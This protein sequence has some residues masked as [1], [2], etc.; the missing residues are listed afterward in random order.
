MRKIWNEGWKFNLN[1]SPEEL[2]NEDWESIQL[3]HDWLIYDTT[4]LYRDGYGRYRKAFDTDAERIKA[5]GTHVFVVFDGVYMD[6][7]YYLNGERIG[8]WKYGYSQ[9]VLELPAALLKK[10]GN[11]LLVTVNYRSPNSRWYSGAGIY[12]DVTY[13]ETP[14]V[15]IPEN[16]VY[17][18]MQKAD[19]GYDVYVD[20]EICGMSGAGCEITNS[21]TD[22]TGNM[23]DITHIL[24]KLLSPDEYEEHI[25]EGSPMGHRQLTS[26][27]PLGLKVQAY[28]IDVYHVVSPREW[29][30]ED[31]YL[32]CLETVLDGQTV[33]NRIGFKTAFCDVDKGFFLNGSHMKLNGVCEHHDLGVLGAEFNKAAMRR[34]LEILRGMGVNAIRGTHNMMA[35]G[36]LELCDEMGILYISEAFDMWNHPKTDYDY[37]R[38]FDDWHERDVASW[39]RRDRNH[40]CVIMWSIGNEIAD[41]HNY[42]KEG[43][44]MTK[45]LM[46]LVACHDYMAN[47]YITQGSNYMPWENAQKCADILKVAGYN[48]GESCYAQHHEEHPDWVIYGSETSSITQSRGV[49]HLPLSANSLGEEDEQCSALGNSTTSWSAKSYELCAAIDRDTPFS[50]GQFLWS[51]FDYIGEPTPYKTRSCYFGQIDTAG[52]PKDSY[53]FWKSCWVSADKDPFVH[54]FPYWDFNEG[55]TVDVRVVSNLPEVELFINGRS[56]GRQSLDHEPGSGYHLIAD[57]RIAY[58]TG[59]LTATAYASA[60]SADVAVRAS[61]HSFGDT[62]HL[63]A[64][65]Y[66]FSSTD[67]PQDI[68]FYEISAVDSEGYAV[69]NACDRVHVRV[70]SGGRL[71]G[72]DNGDS[73]DPDGYRTDSRRLFN[74]KLMV[75]VALDKAN[76]E[77]ERVIDEGCG[78]YVGDPDIRIELEDG[79]KD[80]RRIS[81]MCEDDRVLTPDHRTVKVRSRIEPPAAAGHKMTYRIVDDMGISSHLA[82]LDVS[83]ATAESGANTGE[84]PAVTG[85]ELT[86]TALGDGHFR[87]RATAGGEGQAVRVIS[88]LEFDVEGCGDAFRNP[89]EFI[90]GSTYSSSIGEVGSGNEK[91][92]ATARGGRTV[93]TFDGLDFG[94]YGA[95]RITIPIFALDSDD[96]PL[97]VWKGVPGSGDEI[98]LLD[99]VYSKP[100]QWAVFIEDSWPLMHRVSGV[101]SISFEFERKV[102]VKGFVFDKSD[103]AHS[104]L[105]ATEADAI[106]GDEFTKT[107]TAVEM[108]G[109][110]V[111]LEYKDMDFGTEG[112]DSITIWGRTP[113]ETNPIHVRLFRGDEALKEVCEFTRSEEYVSQTFK[114]PHI[115]GM[116]DVSFVF[117]PG[118]AFDFEAFRFE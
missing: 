61:V 101:A 46:E 18:H 8:E 92:F 4:D 26:G 115:E 47:A 77:S 7:A 73:S 65:R 117:L 106:Y 54:I 93:V 1:D 15:Y 56:L 14:A 45:H 52:F 59:E 108:I 3:P 64:R 82:T 34:K 55:Q 63:V 9:Y 20:T 27:D 89:Y 105:S 102:H 28:S 81:L 6:S 25:C 84:I 99:T 103:K 97:K 98:L 87:L 35:A 68:A 110:N 36:L 104:R 67:E 70:V 57:Y 50:Q 23:V 96:V 111:S 109:N 43:Q 69:E 78:S 44:A 22:E 41:I 24:H 37:A 32:Y 5:E 53:Y 86:I 33:M 79:E 21:L 75:A 74:G 48:Y 118:S 88:D 100:R 95:D 76:D 114:L 90:A 11:E 42:E 17:I 39:V 66:V 38:F 85:D 10:S 12:R 49:Y 80:V 2:N 60:G 107:G 58:E 116:W 19:D 30:V 112:A 31:P 94:S 113:N 83:G 72:M 51:G 62:D 91:G 40:P 29:S 71:I 13:V 16:G